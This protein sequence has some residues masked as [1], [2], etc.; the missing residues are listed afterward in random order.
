M[1]LAFIFLI[2]LPAFLIMQHWKLVIFLVI[3]TVL[4][5]ITLIKYHKLSAPFLW[6]WWRT[7]IVLKESCLWTLLLAII[8][9]NNPIIDIYVSIFAFIFTLKWNASVQ[10]S[11]AYGLVFTISF[12]LLIY[13]IYFT[14]KSKKFWGKYICTSVLLAFAIGLFCG[15]VPSSFKGNSL[16]MFAPFSLILIAYIFIGI[17]ADL[18][19]IIQAI[20]D[21]SSLVPPQQTEVP[22][23]IAPK[24]KNGSTETKSTISN[25][26]EIKI[27]PIVKK[28]IAV[29]TTPITSKIKE[30]RSITPLLG[31]IISGDLD[32][33][34]TAL[35]QNPE[36]LNTAYAQ[37]GN[38]PLHVAALNGQAEIVT[39]LL[40]QPGIDKTLTN[41]AGKT[42]ADLAR[43]KGFAEIAQ[44]LN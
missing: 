41:N 6:G 36:H 15:V 4:L 23:D 5:A 35:Q 25:T 22:L 18:V 19:C 39:L 37:N 14:L 38:T 20:T 21:P 44:L 3:T 42:A 28:P 31:A 17:P 33:V 12:P 24:L 27:A 29:P 32:L 2:C 30:S 13:C 40:E 7:A 16:I 10:D 8:L 34:R 26:N 43:E 9:K 1:F 11:F